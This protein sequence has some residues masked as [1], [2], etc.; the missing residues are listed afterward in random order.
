[1]PTYSI[2]KKNKPI[3]NSNLYNVV[4]LTNSVVVQQLKRTPSYNN[5]EGFLRGLMHTVYNTGNIWFPV[6]I[7]LFGKETIIDSLSAI[8]YISKFSSNELFN[9]TE[10]ITP[11][12]SQKDGSLYI[13]IF[14]NYR[15]IVT[16]TDTHSNDN[17]EYYISE[18]HFSFHTGGKNGTLKD[19]IHIEV[20][21]EPQ[22]TES[23]T[24]PY[25]AKK[26]IL[27]LWQKGYDLTLNPDYPNYYI[28]KDNSHTLGLIIN[29]I[30]KNI[31]HVFELID[32]QAATMEGGSKKKNKLNSIKTKYLREYC[33]KNKLK[34]YSEYNKKD[35]INFIKNNITKKLT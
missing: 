29:T 23:H 24:R 21:L 26:I 14:N 7:D 2:P 3:N 1:M 33:K 4:K 31:K 19:K 9:D 25:L 34:G 35:L 20:N 11:H 15:Q 8:E 18:M 16:V 17:K 6:N 22:P 12:Q 10:Y 32:Y 5:Q 30:I 27:K 13:N 28:Y